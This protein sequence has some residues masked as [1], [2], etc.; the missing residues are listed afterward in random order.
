MS[1]FPHMLFPEYCA[2]VDFAETGEPIGR[3][4]LPLDDG[5][6]RDHGDVLAAKEYLT[7]HGTLT[8]ARQLATVHDRSYLIRSV[9]PEGVTP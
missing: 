6:C 1:D 7:R 5:C 4:W 3:C 9:L 8:S 2:I